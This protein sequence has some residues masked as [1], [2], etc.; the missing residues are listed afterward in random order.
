VLVVVPFLL[1]LAAWRLAREGKRWVLPGAVASLVLAATISPWLI[2]DAMVFHRF[3]PMRDSMGLELWMGN[4]GDNLRWTSDDKHPLHDASELAEYNKGELAYM[5]HK[6]EQAKA[7]IQEHPDWY[8]WMCA[9]RAVYLWTG[10]WSF[11]PAYLAQEPTDPENIPFALGLTLLGLTGL[12][13]T[14][15]GNRLDA[16][17]YGGVFF[18]FPVLYYFNHP[19]PYHMRPLDPLLVMFGCYA[20]VTWRERAAARSALVADAKVL[21]DAAWGNGD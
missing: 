5:E 8:A 2:R 20:I 6:S 3:I 9:R 13:L 11:R 17:R 10:Y 7:Y 19:E 4:N 16:I 18:M 14:W 15:R 21:P 12:L 1:A